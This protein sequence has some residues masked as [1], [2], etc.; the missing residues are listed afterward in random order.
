MSYFY[1]STE[2]AGVTFFC[3]SIYVIRSCYFS[4]SSLFFDLSYLT[5]LSYVYF[6]LFLSGVLPVILRSIPSLISVTVYW[7][8]IYRVFLYIRDFTLN[9][10]GSIILCCSNNQRLLI[11]S[12]NVLLQFQYYYD[13]MISFFECISN[14]VFSFIIYSKVAS[15]FED[16]NAFHFYSW[17]FHF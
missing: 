5:H 7:F 9:S 13:Q 15:N 12:V 11:F 4:A 14:S 1:I 10:M 3:H 2:T 17:Y 8:V 6:F 16:I